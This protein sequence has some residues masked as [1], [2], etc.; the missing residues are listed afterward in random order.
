MGPL[1]T[2]LQLIGEA[3]ELEPEEL[4][5]LESLLET[6]RFFLLFLLV[7]ECLYLLAGVEPRLLLEVDSESLEI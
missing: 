6:L 4:L 1:P 2:P 5:L 7:L 3:S